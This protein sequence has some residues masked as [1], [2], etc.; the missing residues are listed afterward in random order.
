MLISKQ[1]NECRFH[2]VGTAAAQS[3]NLAPVSDSDFHMPVA[4]PL[5][6]PGADES[7]MSDAVDPDSPS[8]PHEEPVTADSLVVVL[9]QALRANDEVCVCGLMLLSQLVHALTVRVCAVVIL[10]HFW[11]GYSTHLYLPS[12]RLGR[13]HFRSCIV[14]Q[15]LRGI[16][17]VHV[18]AHMHLQA[19]VDRV[20]DSS[21]AV[22]LQNT[23]KRLPAPDA[24]L[25]LHALV[26][27]L[28]K[29][30]ARSGMLLPCLKVLLLHH[31]THLAAT[32]A[33]KDQLSTLQRLCEQR[34]SSLHHLL[35]VRGRIEMFLAQ[36]QQ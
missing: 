29:S 4:D 31:S 30:P 21:D 10:C 14:V 36:A 3:D 33:S 27:R 9:T 17:D 35:M 2:T 16:A 28:Q 15:G 18:K 5:M 26:S 20:L 12:P 6:S 34:Y 1:C 11:Y 32:G 19:L 23:V 8:A 13:M 25:L 22:V 24:G 7:G